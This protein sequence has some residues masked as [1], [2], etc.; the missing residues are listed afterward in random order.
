MSP[1]I[2]QRIKSTNI[3]NFDI[4]ISVNHYLVTISIYT[5]QWKLN[6]SPIIQHKMRYNKVKTLI[7]G[8][9]EVTEEWHK[10]IREGIQKSE[11]LTYPRKKQGNT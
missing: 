1:E 5:S 4:A 3:H 8:D 6:P 11:Y 10:S 9:E 2:D 7:E